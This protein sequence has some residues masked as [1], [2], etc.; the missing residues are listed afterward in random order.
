[1][2]DEKKVDEPLDERYRHAEQYALDLR[3]VESE[4]PR[5]YKGQISCPHHIVF[6][7]ECRYCNP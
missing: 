3:P 2:S 1:M 6:V 5:A 4:Q 7:Y